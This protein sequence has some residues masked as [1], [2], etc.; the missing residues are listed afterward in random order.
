MTF[1]SLIWIIRRP[2]VLLS[3]AAPVIGIFY[4]IGEPSGLWDRVSG[5][6]YA[7]MGVRRLETATGYPK[8]WIYNHGSDRQ[9]FGSLLRR[10][11]SRVPR[12]T[13]VELRKAGLRPVLIT[14]GGAPLRL[15]E[16]PEQWQQSYR[17]PI[18][19][20]IRSF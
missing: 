5:R 12:E 8:A 4:A 18:P 7:E 17:F 2:E 1:R 15:P 20:A 19:Q 10:L 3:L 11:E 9:V 6:E 16:L 14:V 13:L